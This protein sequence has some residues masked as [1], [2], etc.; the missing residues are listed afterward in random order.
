MSDFFTLYSDLLKYNPN[1]DERGRFTS[2]GGS[3][4]G[5]SSSKIVDY[6]SRH[7]LAALD[8]PDRKKYKG[9]FDALFPTL[10]GRQWKAKDVIA[11]ARAV[12]GRKTTNKKLAIEA[13]RRESFRR[14]RE[15]QLLEVARTARPW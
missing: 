15:K 4:G 14:L 6:M 9:F 5:K 13:I 3:G 12:T 10:N 1:H 7:I 11:V 2:G 8:Q